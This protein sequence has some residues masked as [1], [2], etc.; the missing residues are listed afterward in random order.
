MKR[1]QKIVF[2][3]LQTLLFLFAIILVAA[4]SD[5]AKEAIYP[6]P[7][8]ESGWK[9]LLVG[10]LG[11]IL[12]GLIIALYCL[13]FNKKLQFSIQV[14]YLSISVMIVFLIPLYLRVISTNS[15]AMNIPHIF[16]S[17]S[18]NI[19]KY[20]FICS[21]INLFKGLFKQKND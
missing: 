10:G 6:N 7:Y 13:N 17:N 18:S 3:V 9:G 21:G 20:G 15:I 8:V 4:L 14:E 2:I 19:I 11:N 1:M 16:L 12:V 5:Y